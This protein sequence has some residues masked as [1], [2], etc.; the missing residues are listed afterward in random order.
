MV[1]FGSNSS[2][3]SLHWKCNISEGSILLISVQ[4][5][6]PKKQGNPSTLAYRSG[7][8]NTIST[9]NFAGRGLLFGSGCEVTLLI[10]NLTVDDGK[11]KYRVKI[12]TTEGGDVFS[13]AVSMLVAGRYINSSLPEGVV[14]FTNEFAEYSCCLI[15]WYMIAGRYKCY[16]L[17]KYI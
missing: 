1:I 10:F 6:D 8:V 11:F 5:F 9:T 13:D 3:V 16:I 17:R 12:T 2:N 14:I 4:R 7:G 15:L